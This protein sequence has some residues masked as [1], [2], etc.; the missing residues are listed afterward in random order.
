MIYFDDDKFDGFRNVVY[1]F[2]VRCWG[3]VMIIF[4][5]G[6]YWGVDYFFFVEFGCSF[7]FVY[8]IG[9]LVG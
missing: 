5:G 4:G 9:R 1:C 6:N 7:C 8:F 3:R 2:G